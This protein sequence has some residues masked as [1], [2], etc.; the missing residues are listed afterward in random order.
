MIIYVFDTVFHFY[1][2][3]TVWDKSVDETKPR[4]CSKQTDKENYNVNIIADYYKVSLAIP[5]IDIVLSKP[6]RRFEGN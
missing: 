3:K 1:Y 5:L 4:V 2:V 6:K